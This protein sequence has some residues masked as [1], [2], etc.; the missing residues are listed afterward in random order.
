MV[1]RHTLLKPSQVAVLRW[2]ADGCPDGVMQGHSYKTTALALQDRRLVTVS[3]KGGT[4]CATLTEGGSYYLEHGAYASP[5]GDSARAAQRR[6]RV[7]TRSQR[8]AA[9]SVTAQ[10]TVTL[11]PS[12]RAV[13]TP[14]D[15]ES[16]TTPTPPVAG[17]PNPPP[18]VSPSKRLPPTEQLVAN[19]LAAGGELAVNRSQSKTNYEALVHS[20]IRFGKVP[21]G[22]ELVVVRGRR[23]EELFIRL[24]DPPAWLTEHLE[25]IAVPVAL[26][27]PHSVVVA[28]RKR[29]SFGIRGPALQ[30]ALLL[31]Q[32]LVT[33][34]ERRGYRVTI[35]RDDPSRRG[36][37]RAPA[38]DDFTLTI[39]GHD[40]GVRVDQQV[41]RAPHVPTA[42]ELRRAERESWFQSPSMTTSRARVCRS[43]CPVPTSIGSP[44]GTTPRTSP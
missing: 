21:A 9:T 26:R 8:P 5:P 37:G 19:V 27:K 34:A 23:W 17:P 22:K 31:V 10:P 12:E 1:D 43:R 42:T 38:T 39:H 25:P 29:D 2:I 30:R 40:V 35:A 11:A 36:H 41:D 15:G 28:L 18:S 44:A 32:A 13:A 20:A 14:V 6:P 3:R 16:G 24:Q 7:Q 33:E 4:W